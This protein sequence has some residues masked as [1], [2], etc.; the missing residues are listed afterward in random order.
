MP[1]KP[2]RNKRNVPTQMSDQEIAG[3]DRLALD[4][5]Q[6]GSPMDRSKVIRLLIHQEYGRRY[7]GQ[8]IAN[9][10]I[11]TEERS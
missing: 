2:A 10:N 1:N 7:K 3:L 4:L 6:D 8:K 5:S 11:P 9:I